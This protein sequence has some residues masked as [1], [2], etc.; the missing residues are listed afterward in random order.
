MKVSEQEFRKSFEYEFSV[1]KPS[2]RYEG[3]LR[4]FAREF[5]VPRPRT[6]ADMQRLMNQKTSGF[7]QLN[8]S[9]MLFWPIG[10]KDLAKTVPVDK[11]RFKSS[12]EYRSIVFAMAMES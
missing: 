12:E 1:G 5:G 9:A 2:I 10:R 4:D 6:R 11:E 3:S 7:F 8:Y